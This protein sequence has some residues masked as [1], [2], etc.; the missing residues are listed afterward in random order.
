GAM[1]KNQNG[2]DIPDKP[3]FV[4][5]LGIVDAY[6]T[7]CPIPYPGPTAPEGYLLM[8]GRAFSKTL[9]PQLAKL[10]ADGYLPDL[11]GMYVRGWDN[12]RSLDKGA[13]IES[14]KE[15]EWSRSTPGY[16]KPLIIGDGWSEHLPPSFGGKY[17]RPLSESGVDYYSPRGYKCEL[18]YGNP[19]DLTG[20]YQSLKLEE[21]ARGLLSEQ[22]FENAF[23]KGL[24][25]KKPNGLSQYYLKNIN[26][27]YYASLI[28]GGRATTRIHSN[29]LA[30]GLGLGELGLKDFVT[31]FTPLSLDAAGIFPTGVPN[32]TF[33]YIT[34]AA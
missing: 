4:R 34:K 6:P 24:I 18:I 33:N 19:G 14:Y 28:D 27:A 15:A 2:A 9:Y 29:E 22:Y 7:G 1:Q 20:G 11:R 17:T 23:S 21:G 30:I 5:T 3:L 12:G 25:E 8:D 13:L 10:Y 16:F 32:V 31:D 26:T